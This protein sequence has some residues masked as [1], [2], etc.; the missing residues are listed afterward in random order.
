MRFAGVAAAT[1]LN[2]ASLSAGGIFA[3]IGVSVKPGGTVFTR[4]GA[5]SMAKAR[6]RPSMALSIAAVKELSMTGLWLQ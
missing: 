1:S 6:P 2:N 5:N 3:D 4:I